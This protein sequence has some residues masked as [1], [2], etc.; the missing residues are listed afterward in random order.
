MAV[1][2]NRIDIAKALLVAAKG[3][4]VKVVDNI[5]RRDHD[6]FQDDNEDSVLHVKLN[7]EELWKIAVQEG[8]SCV[9]EV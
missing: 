9:F 4:H 3:N 1:D 6:A 2:I 5:L 8:L 7:K